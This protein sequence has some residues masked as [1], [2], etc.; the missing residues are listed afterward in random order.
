ML[1]TGLAL[2]SAFGW[3]WADPAAAL[4]IAA[5]AVRE[6][7]EAR[8]GE[9]CCVVSAAGDG[10]CAGSAQPWSRTTAGE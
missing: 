4:V 1:L 3:S 6:G 5:L 10:A 2:N 9:A 8:R 7:I